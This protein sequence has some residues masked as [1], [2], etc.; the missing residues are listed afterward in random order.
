MKQR[1]TKKATAKQLAYIQGL[2][3]QL[4]GK[5]VRFA[6]KLQ[7]YLPLRLR[8]VDLNHATKRQASEIIQRLLEA[9]RQSQQG[10]TVRRKRRHRCR[11]RAG[12]PSTPDT[13]TP[14]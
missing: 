8:A 2:N 6:S 11:P 5:T 14:S 13:S 10:V 12:G 3:R 9:R 4:G 1:D 7:I